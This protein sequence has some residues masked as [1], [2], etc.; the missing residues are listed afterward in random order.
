MVDVPGALGHAAFRPEPLDDI[1]IRD[2][3]VREGPAQLR[4]RLALLLRPR[5]VGSTAAALFVGQQGGFLLD[6]GTR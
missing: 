4:E 1:G 6:R 2:F 3:D 5:E